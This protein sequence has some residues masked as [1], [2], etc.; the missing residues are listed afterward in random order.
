[1]LVMS[2]RGDLVAKHPSALAEEPDWVPSTH[3][4]THSYLAPVAG[5]PVRSS[6]L[7]GLLHRLGAHMYA[8]TKHLCA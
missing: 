4:V 2:W 8:Q 5:D 3:M 6:V 1:M 7:P